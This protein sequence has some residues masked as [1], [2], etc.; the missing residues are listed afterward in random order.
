MSDLEPTKRFSSR[1]DNYVRYRPSY[2]AAVLDILRDEI[3]LD[4]TAVIA[5]L[6]S[7]TGLL[8]KLFLD[9][10]YTVYGVEPNADMRAAGE[11]FLTAYSNFYS[12]DGPAEATTLPDNSV[13]LITA[14]QAFHWFDR[15]ACKPEF[16]RILRPGG[17]VVLVWNDQWHEGSPFMRGYRDLLNQYASNYEQATHKN[18]FEQ[19]IAAF[20]AP[21]ELH[22]RVVPHKQIFDLAGLLGRAQSSSY[23]PLPGNPH[24]EPL[25]TGLRQLFTEHE[26]DGWV[27]FLYQT[28]I[29]WGQW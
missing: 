14:G 1:V 24:Y 2:P 3:G 13:D 8:S 15:E 27:R 29:Y 19:E 6:G 17:Y 7:G 5:D 10:G 12:I 23:N 25:M 16:Q 20:L 4:E 21:A 28:E 11:S 9:N 22:S 18:V 26:D